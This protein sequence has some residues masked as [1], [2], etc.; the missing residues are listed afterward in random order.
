ML[1]WES[2]DYQH[3][4]QP[5]DKTFRN[6]WKRQYLYTKLRFILNVLNL[7]VIL[8]YPRYNN[9]DVHHQVIKF[10][11]IYFLKFGLTY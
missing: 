6:L 2:N 5:H 7:L 1:L 11:V 8:L 4:Y 10:S 3:F 9:I